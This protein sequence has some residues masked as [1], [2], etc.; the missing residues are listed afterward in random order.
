[1]EPHDYYIER[2]PITELLKDFGGPGDKGIQ[3]ELNKYDASIYFCDR[4][5]GRIREFLKQLDLDDKTVVFV[6]SDHGEEFFEHG[7]EGHGQSLYNEVLSVPLVIYIPWMKPATIA[8]TWPV[9]TLD[10]AP[11]ILEILKVPLPPHYKGKSLVPALEGQAFSDR[12]L[13][14]E[15]LLYGDQR[16]A[17][18]FNNYKLI[19]TTTTNEF[20]LY[21]L[22]HDPGDTRNLIGRDSSLERQMKQMLQSHLS[23]A[24]GEMRFAL[25]SHPELGPVSATLTT[26]GFFINVMPF[27]LTKPQPFRLSESRKELRALL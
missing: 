14:A 15:A 21:D 19:Y 16:K 6:T 12:P 20:E 22:E 7:K 10:I 9:T 13:F 8:L 24:P 2:A 5:I 1:M 3:V 18:L 4:E 27:D 11:T 17:V 26:P 23:R 25:Q